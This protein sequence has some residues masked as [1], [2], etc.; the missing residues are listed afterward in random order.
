MR[1][2]NLEWLEDWYQNQCDGDWEHRH[3]MRFRTLDNSGLSLTIELAGTTA[4]H[5][6]PQRISLDTPCGE[7]LTC[8]ISNDRF[9]GSGDPEKLE[10][11]IGIF[12]RWVDTCP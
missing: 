10:Q 1:Q 7:W 8:S 3:G 12:R 11:I 4:A 2:N 5:V 9:E 6:G